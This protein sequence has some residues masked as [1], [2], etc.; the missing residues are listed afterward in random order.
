MNWDN[1]SKLKQKNKKTK[2]Q[3]LKQQL[4]NGIGNM[5]SF[6]FG[7]EIEKDLFFSSC[8]EFEMQK[9]F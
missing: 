6:N 5:V 4:I 9:K 2:K 1:N 3:K 8:Y 7:K